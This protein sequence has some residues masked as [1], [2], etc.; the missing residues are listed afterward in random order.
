MK[1]NQKIEL[2]TLNG[3][4]VGDYYDS[5]SR[6]G[7]ILFPGMAENRYF[8]E[9]T[10]RAL[11][12]EFKTWVFDLSSQGESSGNWDL[13]EIARSVIDV[14]KYARQRYSL[15]KVGA[16]GHSLG[17]TAVG[18]AAANSSESLDC[19]CLST[20]PAGIQDHLPGIGKMLLN[21]VPQSLVRLGSIALDK[22][23]YWDSENYRN[24]VHPQFNKNGN[25]QS[26]AQFG[27]LKVPDAKKIV[28]WISNAPRLDDVAGKLTQ[29]VLMLHA[30]NDIILGIKNGELPYNI[31][32]T[33]VKI[34]SKDKRM[35]VVKGADHWM[36][37]ST[38]PGDCYNN[39][40]EYQFVKDLTFE[41]FASR[42]L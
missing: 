15:S 36:N 8:L 37:K 2:E 11:N 35:I 6:K 20:A 38:K 23:Q 1:E 22:Y 3:R 13:K 40:P 7:I 14:Q 26:Y 39:S 4:L 17:G 31:G 19:L 10:A 42:M 32:Q 18:I 9:D 29:P 33:F 21:T 5:P 27:A 28:E 41:H 30:Q 25:Y 34:G 24:K 16:F 12:K